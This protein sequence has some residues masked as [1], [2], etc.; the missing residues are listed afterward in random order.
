MMQQEVDNKKGMIFLLVV[1]I[2]AAVVLYLISI[3]KKRIEEHGIYQ[4]AAVFKVAPAK[5]G[6]GYHFRYEYKGIF[7]EDVWLSS[8]M[9]S[10]FII[11]FLPENPKK[12]IVV[13]KKLPPC[14]TLKDAVS[15]GWRVLP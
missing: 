12:W 7:Y 6:T 2:L 11:K 15:E 13:D 10:F 1:L 5:N 4:I 9:D 8:G 3:R 14:I